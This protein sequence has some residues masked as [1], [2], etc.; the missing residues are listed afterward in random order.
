MPHRHPHKPTHHVKPNYK[1]LALVAAAVAM[2]SATPLAGNIAS[3]HASPADTMSAT[4]SQQ[5]GKTDDSSSRINMGDKK[6]PVT[7]K[8]KTTQINKT[9]SKEVSPKAIKNTIKHQ[10]PAVNPTTNKTA[11]TTAQKSKDKTPS[12]QSTTEKKSPGS[13]TPPND[14]KKVLDI[15]AT[16]YAPGAHDNDQW[17]DKTYTGTQVRPGIIAVDPDIIPLGSRVYIEYPDG[18]GEYVTAEDT[19]G[20]IKGNRIDIAKETVHEAENFGIQNVKIYV[21]NSPKDIYTFPRG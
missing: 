11:S 18:H 9:S 13:A 21:V 16:A 17:G 10:K 8:N 15:S 19:G 3:A 2:L 4:T 6:S 12:T 14:Y 20:A 7:P 5:V 1:R